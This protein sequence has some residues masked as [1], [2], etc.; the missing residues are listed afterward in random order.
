MP[1]GVRVGVGGFSGCLDLECDVIG[2]QVGM[3]FK[4]GG[5]CGQGWNQVVCV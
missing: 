1:L 3:R 2:E 4:T 5:E